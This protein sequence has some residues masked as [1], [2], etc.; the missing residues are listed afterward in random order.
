MHHN[1]KILAMK[2]S[3]FIL[4]ILQFCFIQIAQAQRT[5]SYG[6]TQNTPYSY[7]NSIFCENGNTDVIVSCAK[8][9]SNSQKLSLTL[10]DNNG[11]TQD[12]K[13][14]ELPELPGNA[15][16][17]PSGFAIE[18]NNLTV[19][20][21]SEDDANGF[22]HLAQ[23]D[24]NNLTLLDITQ[25]PGNF[26][27]GFCKFIQSGNQII[28]YVH[29][30]NNNILR[31]NSSI[32]NI[33]APNIT[34]IGSNASSSYQIST[35]RKCIDVISSDDGIEYA[36]K[37]GELFKRKIDG[38][39]N[40]LDLGNWTS[41][42]GFDLV[43]TN[44]NIIVINGDKFK[45]IDPVSL[46]LLEEGNISG[47]PTETWASLE[48]IWD[49]NEL[50]LYSTTGTKRSS[51]YKIN[52]MEMTVIS[53]FEFDKSFT[54]FEASL[55]SGI[56]TVSGSIQNS[57]LQHHNLG[58]IQL[59][60]GQTPEQFKAWNQ[61]IL[62]EDIKMCIGHEGESFIPT[63]FSGGNEPDG[64]A[65]L[66]EGTYKRIGSYAA[67]G[68]IGINEHNNVISFQ[69]LDGTKLIPGPFTDILHDDITIKDRY[70]QA[71]YVSRAMIEDHLLQI[72]NESY[73]IPYDIKFWPAHGDITK[74]QAAN[75]APF[76]DQNN[77]G[78]YDPEQG[79]YPLIYGEHCYLKI[80]HMNSSNLDTQFTLDMDCF[81]Y[82]YYFNCENDQALNQTIFQTNT[83]YLRSGS[84]DNVYFNAIYDID[85]GYYN[86]DYAG[87]NVNEGMIYAYNGDLNDQFFTSIL[88]ATGMQFLKGAPVPNDD[89]DNLSGTGD[90]QCTNGYGFNDGIIDNEHFTLTSS[91]LL[92]APLFNVSEEYF[93][94]QGKNPDGT[95]QLHNGIPVSHSYFGNSDPNFYTSN[96]VDHDNDNY[97]F[98][99]SPPSTPSERVLQG[100]S[101]PFN[102]DA[103]NQESNVISFTNAFSYYIPD[104]P[105]N[106]ITYPLHGLFIIGNQ[107]KSMY[108]NNT[109]SCDNSFDFYQSPNSVALEEKYILF[110]I[111]P[112]PTKD[113]LHVKNNDGLDFKVRVLNLNGIEVYQNSSISSLDISTENWPSGVY[114]V[115]F[116]SE[117]GSQQEK[118][119]KY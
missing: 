14:I 88:P 28:G 51:Q 29:E 86:D 47:L 40:S 60:A 27:K 92:E 12:Y 85:L 62:H 48:L 7:R 9:T 68:L 94:V 98:N 3:T 58:L 73:T 99:A 8:W 22:Y 83:Y 19:A 61:P 16:L 106:D 80:Y 42:L 89:I 39:I 30:E 115:Q 113:I 77:D 90:N 21:I 5:R 54:V 101:G 41:Y 103:N 20:I 13:L 110:K 91:L 33:S 118:L 67:T 31:I 102:L 96:G 26:K 107:I 87:T 71:F 37:S 36:I 45:L 100:A 66:H 75:L 38:S 82:I 35:G 18:G 6:V 11:I 4:L 17:T 70:N 52:V 93:V 49:N 97:E 57:H 25:I 119:I 55:S 64:L 114:I 34:T 65:I 76:Y 46:T 78:H 109:T 1:H 53:N 79:D 72:N 74:G 95:D 23:F 44:D 69:N 32:N 24:L 63:S 10:L 59:E 104:A 105:I 15:Q 84:Y 112:N 117:K 111:F 81:E 56:H 43:L 116:S 108:N 50:Y 2:N